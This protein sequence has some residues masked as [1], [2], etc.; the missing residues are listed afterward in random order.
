MGDEVVVVDSESTA[1]A[2]VAQRKKQQ[3]VQE[4]GKQVRCAGMPCYPWEQPHA[5]LRASIR[6]ALGWGWGLLGVLACLFEE[7]CAGSFRIWWLAPRC[8]RHLVRFR[9]WKS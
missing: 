8:V 9:V 7:A 4:L 3:E 2:I 6:L 5:V 1:R